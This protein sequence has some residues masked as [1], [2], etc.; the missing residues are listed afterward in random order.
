MSSTNNPVAVVDAFVEAYN[1]KDF[2]R[3]EGIVAEDVYVLHHNR[4]AEANNRKELFGL[5]EAF[6]SAFPDRAFSNRRSVNVDGSTAVVQHTWGGTAAG[7]VPGFAAAG[8]KV[9]LDLCTVVTV[10]DGQIAEYHDYG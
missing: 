10:R 1:A 6:G 4:G 7:D 3:L 9:S 8:E 2:D 5:F